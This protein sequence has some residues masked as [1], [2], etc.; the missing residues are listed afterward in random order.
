MEMLIETMVMFIGTF[1]QFDMLHIGDG[2]DKSP[3]SEKWKKW[4]KWE[5]WKIWKKRI[6]WK[7][8]NVWK[9]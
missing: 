7:K 2:G 5:K 4:K 6:I 3:Y 8:F 1:A 9:K